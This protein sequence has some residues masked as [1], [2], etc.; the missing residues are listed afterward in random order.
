MKLLLLLFPILLAAKSPFDSKIINFDMS[1][2]ETKKNEL[3]ES[4]GKNS[5]IKCR[6]ICDKKVY[7]E[8]KISDAIEF[9]KNSKEY[10]FNRD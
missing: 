10:D 3:N 9:Y 8:Q 7:K 2:Y 1:A 6:F 5:K 4:A